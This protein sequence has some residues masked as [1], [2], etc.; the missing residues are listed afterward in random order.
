MEKAN[1]CR[2]FV[3]KSAIK[4]GKEKEGGKKEEEVIFSF[5]MPRCRV[6]QCET[7]LF[8]DDKMR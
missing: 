1:A 3:I 6:S 8:F 5:V 7:R 2:A 4:N